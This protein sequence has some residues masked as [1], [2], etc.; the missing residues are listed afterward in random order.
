MER[1]GI[2]DS[3]KLDYYY[4]EAMK[5]LR[6]NVMFSGKDVKAIL[7]TS[8]FP[9]EGKS[10]IAMQLA[11]D[12]AEAGKHV[13]LF[14]TDIRKSAMI[15]R[16][17][18]EGEIKGLSQYLSGQ[19]ELSQILYKT[20]FTN[21]DVLFSGPSVPNPSELL[22]TSGFKQ[23]LVGLRRFYD[24]IIL[25][26]PPLGS[27]IDAAIVATHCDGAILVLEAD[28]VTYRE[29]QRVQGQL[30]KTGCKILGAVLNKVDVKKGRY[31]DRY[32]YYYAGGKKG[33]ESG[34]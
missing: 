11:R 22:E 28:R 14:D 13:V 30:R 12:L 7:V 34:I 24:Y 32:H 18:V 2:K 21:M 1:I 23:L 3:R 26:C 17:S 10:D 16:Y 27:V 6:T 4:V 19:A 9:N 29:A 8:T 33:R 20:N 15:R 5:T 25:D 31:Y